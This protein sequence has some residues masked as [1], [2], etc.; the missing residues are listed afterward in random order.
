[1]T[2]T[3]AAR[4]ALRLAI[5]GP[6][7]LAGQSLRAFFTAH[8]DFCVTWTAATTTEANRLLDADPPA[9]M[10]LD[11]DLMQGSLVDLGRRVVTG[12]ETTKTVVLRSQVCM[13][14]LKWVLKLKLSGYLL[15][16]DA[17]ETAIA[18][19]KRAYAGGHCWSPAVERRLQFH[20]TTNT[21]QLSDGDPAERLTPRQTEI[22][23]HLAQG[24]SAKEV[25]R[26]LHL[27]E[28][29]INSHTYRIMKQLDIHD[30]VELT[31]FAIREG[32]IDP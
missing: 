26:Y 22:V 19:I 18:G 1:M 27:A 14:T 21:Y 12:V 3:S 20:S 25:A 15:K 6:S 2:D 32:L 23:A 5:V 8:P 7:T 11:A 16:D 29:S 30:R 4:P 9:V 31:R 24:A 17:P 13:A 28:K 10:L